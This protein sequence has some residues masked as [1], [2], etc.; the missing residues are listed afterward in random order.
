LK[1]GSVFAVYVAIGPVPHETQLPPAPG[2][3]EGVTIT[4]WKWGGCMRAIV[5][6]AF[7]H[8]KLADRVGAL[9]DGVERLARQFGA[10]LAFLEG[11]G[12]PIPPQADTS[13][14]MPPASTSVVPTPHVESHPSPQSRR[15]FPSHS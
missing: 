3:T 7:G 11:H 4:R 12:L 2:V 1:L 9:E 15:P 5:V 14:I 13:S 8:A 6:A 10:L